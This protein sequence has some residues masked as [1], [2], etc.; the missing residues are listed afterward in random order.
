MSAIDYPAAVNQLIL[1]LRQLPGI[2]P[3]SAERIALWMLRDGRAATLDLAQAMSEALQTV[4]SCPDCG[5]F[6]TGGVCRLCQDAARDDRLLC[7]VEQAADVLPIERTGAFRGRYHVLGGRLSPLDNIG[8]AQL[9]IAGLR[10]RVERHVDEVI[11][12][13][14]SDVEGE[15]TCHFLHDHLAGCGARLTRL[16]QGLPA[17]GGL[18]SADTLTVMRALSGRREMDG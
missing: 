11:L 18:E 15:A 4:A 5:F 14:G 9:R 13:L 6:T 7:V 17:G 10:A 12:A 2:G 1:R 16:A 8:P 3:R